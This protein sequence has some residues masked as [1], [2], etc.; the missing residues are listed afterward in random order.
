[1]GLDKSGINRC[2]SVCLVALLA[3]FGVLVILQLSATLLGPPSSVC[4]KQVCLAKF[5]E[6][7]PA[8]NNKAMANYLQSNYFT[9]PASVEYR[10]SGQD[11]MTQTV[12][13]LVAFIKTHF[14]DKR[15]GVFLEL[16]TGDGEYR[17]ITLPLERD[18]G[19]SGLLV[20]PHPGLYK[21][22]LKKARKASAARLCVS[23]Y[24]YPAKMKLAYPK[25]MEDA[26]EE[27]AVA[28]MGK[29]KLEVLWD[30]VTL[31]KNTH[32][33]VEVQC[34]P[35]E[36]LIYAGGL[37]STIDLMVLDMS[38]TDLDLLLNTKL[39]EVPEI[40][41]LVVSANGGDISN[42][43]A[44]YFLERNMVMKRVFGTNPQ[45]AIYVLTKFDARKDM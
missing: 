2:V 34:V 16:G 27:E 18:L 21:K 45:D 12:K 42:D 9:P 1:M 24:S 38:G 36:N 32:E 28:E 4:T 5:M 43:I 22:L 35:L 31:A 10:L 20:E 23:P 37:T 19:W 15:G 17:S 39:D 33:V 8:F 14:K 6:G 11:G 44:G 13:E 30:K 25:V 41:M 3:V 29:T 40:E 7:P 26:T